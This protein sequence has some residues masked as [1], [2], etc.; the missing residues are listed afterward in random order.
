MVFG[1]G[2]IGAAKVLKERGW[3]L[4][5][6]WEQAGPKLVF[7]I[8]EK[9]FEITLTELTDNQIIVDPEALADLAEKIIKES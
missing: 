3:K 4:D 7:S 9:L 8:K 6:V 5:I 1:T 2:I